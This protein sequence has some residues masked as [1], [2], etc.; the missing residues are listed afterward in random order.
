[1]EPVKKP[2]R[3]PYGV[4]WAISILFGLVMLAGFAGLFVAAF[5]QSEH[6][7]GDLDDII[8]FLSVGLMVLG[9]FGL[10]I[11]LNYLYPRYLERKERKL[12]ALKVK[13]VPLPSIDLGKMIAS[14]TPI[15]G[16]DG[17]YRLNLPKGSLDI[18]IK[19][20]GE[21]P[22][23]EEID[24][25]ILMRE[26]R[27]DLEAPKTVLFLVRSDLLEGLNKDR[28]KK[29]MGRV[30][31][32]YDGCDALPLIFFH[33]EFGGH[34]YYA[35]PSLKKSSF[36]QAVLNYFEPKKKAAEAA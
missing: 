13:K 26:Y 18:V 6:D 28:L 16:E 17:V 23:D 22:S 15:E 11:S 29:A 8:G 30:A 33:A 21:I 4:L 9:C 1:M 2:Y 7:V 14:W 35:L 32:L 24:T 31:A 36:P 19:E 5:L 10:G 27:K 20:N 12:M 34:L 25:Y 3:L